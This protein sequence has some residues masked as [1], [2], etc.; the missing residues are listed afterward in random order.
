VAVEEDIGAAVPAGPPADPAAVGKGGRGQSEAGPARP[1]VVVDA[2]ALVHITAAAGAPG[3]H[4]AIG[5]CRAGQQ[6]QGLS[7]GGSRLR[8]RPVDPRR[9][10]GPRQAGGVDERSRQSG[11]SRQGPVTAR[12]DSIASKAARGQR[13]GA[14]NRGARAEAGDESR[15][16]GQFQGP[17]AA[18]DHRADE[19]RAGADHQ[20]PGL[21]IDCIAARAGR[22]L[23]SGPAVAFGLSV[24]AGPGGAA[25]SAIAA[26]D[27][28]GVDQSPAVQIDPNPPAA[29][30]AAIT[31]PA[32]VI[33]SIPSVSASAT[34]AARPAGDRSDIVELRPGKDFD[35]G[36]AAAARTAHASIA[37]STIVVL[38]E[39][40]HADSAFSARPAGSAGDHACIDEAGARRETDARATRVARIAG[41]PV[42]VF[43]SRLAG[44]AAKPCPARDHAE[45][46]Q[47]SGG[48]EVD[49]GPAAGPLAPD[50]VAGVDDARGRFQQYSV[51]AA[52]VGSTR[53]APTPP[54]IVP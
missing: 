30:H 46:M 26:A 49:A 13:F 52:G 40:S 1:T 7:A 25:G 41:L 48:F 39:D 54:R 36:A 35:S 44:E 45:V 12:V 8:R 34:D 27:R 5:P 37:G 53:G 17:A 32:A 14:G 15:P 47:I 31:A 10:R 28:P 42:L 23:R 11:G 24:S 9:S 50:Y 33:V 19:H 2:R 20:G 51:A 3:D 38:V 6:D 29:A 21:H 22:P 16:G 4:A 43:G 18:A